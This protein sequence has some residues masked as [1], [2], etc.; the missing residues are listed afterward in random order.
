MSY[1]T[2]RNDSRQ[3]AHTRAPGPVTISLVTSQACSSTPS[4][5]HLFREVGALPHAH[6]PQRHRVRLSGRPIHVRHAPKRAVTEGAPL[7]FLLD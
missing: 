1:N 2:A 3:D 6:V 4:C 7:I 5:S